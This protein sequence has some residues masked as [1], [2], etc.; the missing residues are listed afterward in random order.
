MIAFA[1]AL[2]HLTP[3]VLQVKAGT[4]I[5]AHICSQHSQT[6]NVAH[7]ISKP[8]TV[9]ERQSYAEE[10]KSLWLWNT[11]QTDLPKLPTTSQPNPDP[12]PLH[13]SETMMQPHTAIPHTMQQVP[14]RG[15]WPSCLGPRAGRIARPPGPPCPG[16]PSPGGLSPSASPP[17]RH[18]H[19]DS[20]SGRGVGKVG[21]AGS[22]HPG[23]G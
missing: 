6:H 23:A 3:P 16:A 22:P 18:P 20:G 13:S 4:L 21:R 8:I 15:Y 2:W 1:F 9:G 14:L 7:S 5:T 12:Q 17:A 11:E 19:M 10:E